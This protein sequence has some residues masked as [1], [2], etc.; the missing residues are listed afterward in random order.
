MSEVKPNRRHEQAVARKRQRIRRRLLKVG[1]P[2]L[3]IL[4][5]AGSVALYTSNDKDPKID[6]SAVETFENLAQNH[7]EEPQQY[8]QNPPVGGDHSSTWQNCGAYNTKIAS[9]NAVH[10]LEHGAVWI[11]YQPTLPSAQINKL[12]SLSRQPGNNYLLVS[13]LEGIPTPVAISA[14]G[15][16]LKLENVDD[17]RLNEFIK[18]YMQG[19]QTPEPGASCLGGTGRPA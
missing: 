1:L 17:P 7:V 10:A 2:I 3:V 6:M 19:P 15:K 9:E 18:Q 13:P 5:I 14:W 16:Q 8:P 12:R 4:L 11:T